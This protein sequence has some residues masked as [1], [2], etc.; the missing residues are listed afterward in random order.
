MAALAFL[1]AREVDVLFLDVQM[2]ELTGVDLLRV[3]ERRPAVILTTA[4]SE[5]AVEGYALDVTD[6]LLKSITFERFLAAVERV[7]ERVRETG[8]DAPAEAI[9]SILAAPR[10]SGGRA[11]QFDDA[12]GA[13]R[14]RRVARNGSPFR[15]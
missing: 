12:S 2:P 15:S 3:L 8:M 13:V 4:Y 14:P 9:P 7:G 1:K 11:T 10:L 6:Y 5:Y